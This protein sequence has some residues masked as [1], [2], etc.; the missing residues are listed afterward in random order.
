MID[1]LLYAAV[2]LA[3]LGVLIF[4]PTFLENLFHAFGS[5]PAITQLGIWEVSV[6]GHPRDIDRRHDYHG[7]AAMSPRKRRLVPM[8]TKRAP[9]SHHRS[10]TN[11]CSTER[12][13]DLAPNR[14]EMRRR[15]A[16]H[17]PTGWEDGCVAVVLLLVAG[18]FA[19]RLLAVHHP[20][21]CLPAWSWCA[22]DSAGL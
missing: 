4:D 18:G 7:A 13:G 19:F 6:A 3:L 20:W 17:I 16:C 1:K 8:P 11:R 22:A 10:L 21:C 12:T 2:G 5:P 9:A 14:D 15:N